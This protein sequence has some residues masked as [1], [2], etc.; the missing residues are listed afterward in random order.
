M[1]VVGLT[2][3][4]GSGKSVVARIFESLG[5]QVVDTD[6]IAR[7]LTQVGGIANPPI[8]EVFGAKM[9]GSAGE[10]NRE[11]M[12]VLVFNDVAARQK[13]EAIL[14]PLIYAQS[15]KQLAS[16]GIGNPYAILVIPLLF[17]CLTFRALLWRTLAIDCAVDMQIARVGARSGLDA[18]EIRRIVGAQTPRAIR[19][20]LANDVVR[21]ESGI[22]ALANLVG[23][24]HVGYLDQIKKAEKCT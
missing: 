2:G 20:Q 9:L 12:R 18:A 7:Q 19:L 6:K 3:G 21:N 10:L 13:L 16:I 24:L 11:K 23:Q 15:K 8:G 17:E 22:E 5:V 14:H 4:I 1:K